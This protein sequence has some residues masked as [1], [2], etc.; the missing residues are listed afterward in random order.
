MPN[1]I[2]LVLLLCSAATVLQAAE[3]AATL[4]AEIAQHGFATDTYGLPIRIESELDE[5]AVRATIYGFL[6]QPYDQ[7]ALLLANPHRWC[8]FITLVLNI[9]A[10]V[11]REEGDG[12]QLDVYAGRKYYEPPE[13]VYL[14]EYRYRLDTLRHDYVEV[15]LTAPDGPLNT[16]DYRIGIRAVPAPDGTYLGLHLAYRSSAVSRV[17][18]RVYLATIGRNKVGFTVIER[19]PDGE[20]QY[21]R[22]VRG[23]IERNVVRY[24]LALKAYLRTV[25][26]EAPTRAQFFAAAQRWYALA[27][28]FPRQLRE[29]GRE[30]YL[31]NKAA[32]YRNQRRLQRET[33]LNV[34]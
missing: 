9:K 31:E 27:E 12:R 10:C 30:R 8:G 20:P 32:E 15:E 4:R 16:E 23:I 24:Y 26:G 21:I 19:G 18:V 28:H 7:V 3:P 1:R 33:G 17:A 13:D 5:G 34:Y 22:G 29:L 6:P 2:V 25:G 11:Y 14:F